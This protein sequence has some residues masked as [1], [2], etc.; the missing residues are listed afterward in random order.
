MSLFSQLVYWIWSRIGTWPRTAYLT[1]LMRTLFGRF[2]VAL[3]DRLSERRMWYL[4]GAINAHEVGPVQVQSIAVS[5]AA[6]WTMNN[7]SADRRFAESR[8][9]QGKSDVCFRC[10]HINTVTPAQLGNLRF[11][12]ILQ[13]TKRSR[14]D[15]AVL[16]IF[17]L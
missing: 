2:F 7:C 5:K 1:S 3:S 10:K 6:R 15:W 4:G 14:L 8:S 17:R 12:D 13:R 11:L 16:C 9:R